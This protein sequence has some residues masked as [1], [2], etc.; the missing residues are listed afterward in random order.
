MCWGLVVLDIGK[1]SLVGLI[2]D[3]GCVADLYRI[4]TVGEVLIRVF[5]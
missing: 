5:S 1:A 2:C 3:D 4:N